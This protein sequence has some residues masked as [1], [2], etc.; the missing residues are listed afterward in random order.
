MFQLIIFFSSAGVL[1]QKMPANIQ[2]LWRSVDWHHRVDKS[3]NY[4]FRSSLLHF[5]RWLISWIKKHLLNQLYWLVGHGERSLLP[6]CRRTAGT[7]PCHSISWAFEC[8]SLDLTSQH[9][10]D[11]YFFCY[12]NEK[13]TKIQYLWKTCILYSLKPF[14]FLW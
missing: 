14:K 13:S 1:L 9:I 6:T 4:N 10:S 5:N 3:W 7:K 2:P 8:H 12:W 11:T